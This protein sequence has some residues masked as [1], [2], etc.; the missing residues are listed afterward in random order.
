[1]PPLELPMAWAYSHRITGRDS[2]VSTA[3]S[4]TWAGFEYMGQTMSVM[5]PRP[6][7]QVMTPS[8]LQWAPSYCTGR[9]RS[10]RR[11]HAAHRAKLGPS[12]LSLPRD[13]VITEAWL[14]ARSTMARARARKAFPHDGV[15]AR[16]DRD[17]DS[18]QPWVSMLAS[19]TT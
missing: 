16:L 9:V 3:L 19:S 1:M 13:Q 14:R 17:S 2:A 11:I 12:P 4:R 18:T 6:S 8:P 10:V 7:P 5:G 15:E